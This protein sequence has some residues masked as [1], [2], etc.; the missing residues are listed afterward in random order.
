MSATAETLSRWASRA[1]MTAIAAKLARVAHALIK[2]QS[3][4]RP[5]FEAAIPSGRT[6]VC[7]GREGA[8]R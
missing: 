3:D 1:A 5:F 4:Y 6:P 2:T 7:V 8:A